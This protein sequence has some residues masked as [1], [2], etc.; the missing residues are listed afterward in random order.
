VSARLAP[1]VI[2]VAALATIVIVAPDT[3][4]ISLAA[5]IGL[6]AGLALA[7]ILGRAA[8]R[9][10]AAADAER[11]RLA[12]LAREQDLARMRRLET[13]RR[14][15]VANVSHELRTPLA[16]LKAMVEALEGGA[17]R[18]AEA[19]RDFLGRMH[20]EVDD[21]TQLVNELL[22][23]SRAESGQEDLHIEDLEPATIVAAAVERLRPLAARSSVDL[24][25]R[26]LDGL[27]SVRGDRDRIAQVLTNLLHNAIKFTP[28]GGRVEVGAAPENGAV[29]FHVRDSGIGLRGDEVE[30]VFER[31]YKGERSRAGGGTGLGLALAKHIVQ[32]HGGTISAASP[33][34]GGGSTFS[35]TLPRADAVR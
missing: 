6:V 12:T 11:E 7:T 28:A 30:R 24:W 13:V 26:R 18:D 3:F 19:A 14:D 35:F 20:T 5:L 10:H 17:M 4:A 9:E 31:F 32:A 33:G 1:A 15:F 21:L 29:R 16:S 25:I 27:P 22:L 8:A 2:V 23:L 34:P